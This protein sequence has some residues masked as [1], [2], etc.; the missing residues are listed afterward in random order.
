LGEEGFTGFTHQLSRKASSSFKNLSDYATSI[1]PAPIRDAVRA[2]INRMDS[3]GSVFSTDLSEASSGSFSQRDNLQALPEIRTHNADSPDSSGI[4]M[5]PQNYSSKHQIDDG[6]GRHANGE[7]DSDE[8]FLSKIPGFFDFGREMKQ[9]VAELSRLA[10]GKSVSSPSTRSNSYTS[11]EV[12]GESDSPNRSFSNYSPE[13]DQSS[14]QNPT[15]HSQAPA[16]QVVPLSEASGEPGEVLETSP[17]HLEVRDGKGKLHPKI[18][19]LP[20]NP[21]VSSPLSESLPTP[22]G[23]G[24][25]Y[26]GK[27]DSPMQGQKEFG[28][29]VERKASQGNT[30]RE[31]VPKRRDELLIKK[32]DE[33]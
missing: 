8:G 15:F 21:V 18:L 32:N 26:K 12:G 13:V 31:E 28:E 19:D 16:A 2:G 25:A 10:M 27:R 14:S 33:D 1:T 3:I 20:P 30:S 9:R 24:D 11:D 17:H 4:L 6:S 5:S 7:V 29:E 23:A 22:Q